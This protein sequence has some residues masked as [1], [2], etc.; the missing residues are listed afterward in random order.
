MRSLAKPIALLLSASYLAAAS[1]S[2]SLFAQTTPHRPGYNLL[3]NPGHEHP[4]VYFAG[5]GEINVT[6]SWVP[7]WEEPPAGVDPRDP[8]YRTPEFRPVFRNEYP[9]RVHSGAGSDRWF[10]FFALN[11]KAGIMQ[12]VT[13]LPIGAPLRFTT[14]VQ[15]WSTNLSEQPT[16]PPRSI[17]DGNLKVRVCIDQDGGP[18][19]MTDP[20]LV[21]SDWKQPYDR[22][23]QISVDGVAKNTVVNVLIWSS[24]EIPVEHNDIYADDSCLEVLPASGDKGIC[25]GQGFVETGPGVTPPPADVVNIRPPANLPTIQTSQTAPSQPE[26]PAVK[27]PSG[28]KPALAVNAKRMLN[29]RA[30]PNTSAKVIAKAERGEVLTVTGKS[31]DSKWFLVTRKGKQGWVSS[32]L[33]LPNAAARNAPVITTP[34]NQ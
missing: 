21:C 32:G 24:A 29:L 3:L 10:N 30:E 11:R 31:A 14:W 16:I 5:R 28:N 27:A 17:Q 19:D 25:L 2:G 6:W 33:T 22:W 13:N 12:Y 26:L 23:E 20:N 34:N 1:F 4:G 8:Y 7:F 9:Y 18:R 15:L